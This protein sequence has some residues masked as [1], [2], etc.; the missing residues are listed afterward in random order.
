MILLL[1]VRNFKYKKCEEYKSKKYKS[2]SL[3]LFLF[4]LLSS[5]DCFA[6]TIVCSLVLMLRGILL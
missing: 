2:L 3:L 4:T 5:D 1:M 6:S